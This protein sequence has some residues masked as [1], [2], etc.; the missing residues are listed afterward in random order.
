MVVPAPPQA[1]NRPAAITGRLQRCSVWRRLIPFSGL[2]LALLAGAGCHPQRAQLTVPVSNWPGYEYIYLASE[3][4]LASR[5]GLDLRILQFNDPQDIVHG[6]LRG[7]LD[8]AQLTTVEA[9][10]LC[11]RAPSRCPVVVLVLDESR[12]GDQVAV[13]AGIDTIAQLRGR[14]VGVTHSTLGPY[15]LSR[16]LEREG[17]SLADVRLRN[18]PLAAMPDALA[19]GAVD[20]VAFYPPYST[21]A[22]RRGHART[23]FDSRAIPGEIFDVL[24]VSPQVLNRDRS[25]LVRLLRAWQAAHALARSRPDQ[26]RAPMAR[27]EGLSVQEFA[28]AERGLVYFSLREQERLLAG[29]GPL[30][31]NLA[32]VQ[33]VQRHLGL[34]AG[35]AP[36]PQVTPTLVQA[37]LR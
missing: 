26:A 32:A 19:R 9:V 17:L 27:R 20:A 4:G 36:L 8:L 37:A 3:R 30:A 28:E 22:A 31:R 6:Y 21:V 2:A 5:Q 10:D 29:A 33:R 14:P 11:Y 1:G 35:E 25:A 12:G 16:A 18:M 7:E 34:H 23:L 13:R 15:V 24:V